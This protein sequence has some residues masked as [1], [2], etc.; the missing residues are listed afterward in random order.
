MNNQTAK[1]AISYRI[2]SP[3]SNL[4]AVLFMLLASSSAWGVTTIIPT[5]QPA[6]NTLSCLGTRNVGSMNCSAQEFT[7]GTTFSAAP[8]TPPFC[9]AGSTFSFQVE[10][11]LSGS[12]A[13]RY[14]MAFYTGETGNDPQVNDSSKFCSVATFP[15]TPLPYGNIDNY[16]VCG[17]YYARGDSIITVNQIKSL[18]QGDSVGALQIPYT[19]TYS[20]DQSEACTGPLDVRPPNSP[21]KC[22]SATASVSGA[23][24]V[25]SGA[26]VDVTKQTSPDGD[27]QP[28]TFTATGPAGSKVIA[29]TG[30]TLTATTAT[31]GTY[32]P[33][34]I[35]VATNTTSVT[36][37]DGQT[38]RFYINALAANQTLTITE[39]PA[40]NWET[41]AD[42]TCSNV[43]GAPATTID[44][45]TRVITAALNSTNS[46]AAC[47]VT[48]TKRATVTKSFSPAIIA[49]GGT[50][51]LTFT[52]NNYAASAKTFTLTDNTASGW[53]DGMTVVN[54]IPKSNSCGGSL[55]DGNNINPLT[56]A[57]SGNGF[58][59]FSNSVA[60]NSSCTLVLTVTVPSPTEKVY[61]DTTAGLAYAG[62]GP[63]PVS[64]TATLSAINPPT[65]TKSFAPANIVSGGNS[66]LTVTIGNINAS[67]I[68]LTSIFTDTFP[69]GMTI[70][71]AGNT[72]TCGGV[73]ASAGA[74]NFTIANGTSIPA[75]GCTVIV[76]V[77][78]STVGATVNTIAAGTLQT[79]AVGNV[80]PATATLTVLTPPTITKAFAAPNIGLDATT[81]LNLTV[82]NPNT[83]TAL[84]GIAFTDTLPAGLTA[85]NGTTATCGGSLVITGTNLLTFTGGT[86]AANSSC[87]ITT[88]ITGT[89][90]GVKSNTTTAV[91]ASGP[92]ALTGA[93]SNTTSVTVSAAPTIANSF[94][95]ANVTLNESVNAS[96]LIA[97][98]N[99]TAL[100][101]IAF[102]DTLPA[103]LS[104]TNGSTATCGGNMVITGGNLLTFTG[105]ALAASPA[106]CTITVTVTGTTAG[107][108][109]NTTG[110]ISSTE[111]GTGTTSNTATVNVLTL[112]TITKAFTS[113]VDI[114]ETSTMTFTLSNANGIPMTSV[115][116]TDTL[117]G[118]SVAAPTIG[119]T[120]AGVTN[121]PAL[122]AGATA[123]NLTVPNL[124]AGSCTI[125][126]P[127]TASSTGSYNNT[128]SG[129]TT[130]ETGATVGLPSNTATLAVVFLP[131]QVTKSAVMTA[132]PGTLVSYD[133]GY[134]N[135]N[136]TTKLQ[137]IVITDP[138][139]LY[140]TYD[141]ASCVGALPAT[142][143]SCTIVF[144][145]PPAGVG[146][147][148]VTWT[149]GGTLDAGSSGSVQL[150][151]RIQ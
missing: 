62:G 117:T 58:Y 5:P 27:T 128:T 127:V 91:T 121:S 147:G 100:S 95:A 53:P 93:V 102:T 80:A 39:D 25:Y 123:L 110:V 92:I 16:N 29:L 79:T 64:N 19:L 65:V 106:N 97:N 10:L 139:P 138:V 107:V 66:N 57:N 45:A 71:T 82:T 144:T 150:T 134:S 15:T 44:N 55:T 104:A 12:N 34:T 9:I 111:S 13:N 143:T 130:T 94:A 78:S 24:A 23:V 70:S 75:G 151:V 22:Q 18:C 118:F 52:I 112:P 132:S 99:T 59:L 129:I 126:I 140:T 103:G 68:S 137:S 142:I 81:A 11:A 31:G 90:A 28:F 115:N 1:S 120:C 37:T 33:A 136:A 84:S 38:A 48:N 89:T 98:P 131:L 77:T 72:G 96:F 61:S 86:L 108:K 146:N 51:D 21:A 17:D 133:I 14:N 30:A 56:A 116:F 4:F 119:G 124:A 88:N 125:T 87:V 101:G 105:G 50:S 109:N 54:P 2:S 69:A 135:P 149:L 148:I 8:G 6:T 145:P 46:A 3:A 122:A 41:T 73:T 67:A 26:F 76:N 20:V 60:A 47:T 83:T 141:S 32:T 49:P 114:Y 74:N 40:T 35:G 63:G 43:T 85:V 113:P 7:V 42:I 36:L